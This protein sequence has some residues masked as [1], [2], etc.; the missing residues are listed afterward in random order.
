MV[1]TGNLH[2][3]IKLKTNWALPVLNR[4]L[5]PKILFLM[6]IS[7]KSMGDSKI[8]FSEI[9]K[10]KDLIKANLHY[11]NHKGKF[12]KQKRNTR[13]NVSGK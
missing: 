2:N 13:W 10:L 3:I 7:V 4:V 9:H 6:K 1:S 8:P 5:G 12:F 11:R